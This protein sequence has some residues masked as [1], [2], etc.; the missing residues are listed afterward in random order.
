VEAILIALADTG[1]ATF[2]RVSWWAY[3]LVNIVHL[4]G[5]AALFGAILIHDLRLVGLIRESAV[6]RTTDPAVRIAAAGLAVA[7]G[8]GTLLFAVRPL[9]YVAMPVFWAKLAFVAAG[10][11]TVAAVY[12]RRL[13]VLRPRLAGGLSLAAWA[14]A[15][16][17]GR[18]IGYAA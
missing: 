13:D 10:L 5:L 12:A 9:D 8:S 1:P 16:I 3:P 11:A 6:G 7:L 18:L 14:G 17:T 15:I 4:F 2:L